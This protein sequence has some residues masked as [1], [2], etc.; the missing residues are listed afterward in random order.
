M[1]IGRQS[2]ARIEAVVVVAVVTWDK[3]LFSGA[4]G[5]VDNG[6]L[7]AW[8]WTGSHLNTNLPHFKLDQDPRKLFLGV[9]AN[10]ARFAPRVDVGQIKLVPVLAVGDA[11][12][13]GGRRREE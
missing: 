2:P 5:W 4:G 10:Q 8:R 11:K 7:I 13:E 9:V 12:K 3:F 6:R 1:H